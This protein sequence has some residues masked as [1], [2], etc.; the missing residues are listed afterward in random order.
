ML[1]RV[2]GCPTDKASGLYIHHHVGKKKRD[3]LLTIYSEL[4]LV[5][6]SYK[7]LQ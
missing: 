3:K 4:N 1:A 2:A 5:Y 6:K 7:I